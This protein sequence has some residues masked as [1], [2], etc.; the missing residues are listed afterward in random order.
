[1]QIS[2][3][4]S[5][6]Q[7]SHAFQRASRFFAHGR[8]GVGMAQW[9]A[10]VYLSSITRLLDHAF[11]DA[12]GAVIVSKTYPGENASRDLPIVRRL[13]RNVAF[14]SAL[15]EQSNYLERPDIQDKIQLLLNCLFDIESELKLKAF[16]SAPAIEDKELKTQLS[17]ASKLAIARI[18]SSGQAKRHS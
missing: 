9:A 17:T 16:G 15:L 18:L 11:I 10:H 12:Q 1:M 6:A 14:F 4:P 13:I 5:I 8:A 2:I 7:Q 3:A